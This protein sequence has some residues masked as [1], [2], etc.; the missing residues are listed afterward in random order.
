MYLAS[1]RQEQIV[2]AVHVLEHQLH[3]KQPDH[4]ENV[5]V[6]NNA[7]N[8]GCYHSVEKAH[9]KLEALQQPSDGSE[10]IMSLA[11]TAAAEPITPDTTVLVLPEPQAGSSGGSSQHHAAAMTS[12]TSSSS[13]SSG[14]ATKHSTEHGTDSS[15]RTTPAALQV[16]ASNSGSGASLTGIGSPSGA[17]AL[18][19]LQLLQHQQQQQQQQQHQHLPWYMRTG[20]RHTASVST[21]SYC[22]ST[23]G[24]VTRCGAIDGAAGV[25]TTREHSQSN[26]HHAC[27]TRNAAPAA[28]SPMSL[29]GGTLNTWR[30]GDDGRPVTE[31]LQVRF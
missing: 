5:T 19:L 21:G 31:R 24:H 23:D 20:I 17:L 6:L 16:P 29:S 11:A 14:T 15:C 7:G 9:S 22:S 12:T 27:G 13:S 10:S 18:Q 3:A 4:V 26:R 25:A 2:E 30:S 28:T 1:N 8:S